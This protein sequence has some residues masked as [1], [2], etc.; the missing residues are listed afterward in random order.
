MENH[1]SFFYLN[2]KIRLECILYLIPLGRLNITTIESS[3]K[4]KFWCLPN[5]ICVA[6][7]RRIYSFRQTWN[8]PGHFD[9][10]IS[11]KTYFHTF[12]SS[13]FQMSGS[14]PPN[15][16]TIFVYFS[17]IALTKRPPVKNHVVDINLLLC[18]WTISHI[19]LLLWGNRIYRT[20]L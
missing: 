9:S 12:S 18:F 15:S 2:Q 10:W 20:F 11:L 8:R 14:R 17:L 4:W 3:I 19:N 1:C 7:K 16:G 5:H 6:L 13:I